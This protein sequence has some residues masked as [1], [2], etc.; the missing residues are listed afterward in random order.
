MNSSKKKSVGDDPFVRVESFPVNTV[1]QIDQG[2]YDYPTNEH[3]FV[4]PTF[5]LF[6]PIELRRNDNSYY[7]VRRAVF[8]TGAVLTLIPTEVVKKGDIKLDGFDPPRFMRLTSVLATSILSSSG[9]QPAERE[10]YVELKTATLSFPEWTDKCIPIF[11]GEVPVRGDVL[12]G[13]NLLAQIQLLPSVRRIADDSP[14]CVVYH[15]DYD[16]F[17]VQLRQN[18]KWQ[19]KLS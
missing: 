3:W 8:D 13:A 19:N 9:D 17:V 5:R 12:L 2:I 1:L 7:P 10:L 15:Q 16:G 11:C 18:T 4:L 6:V 14:E